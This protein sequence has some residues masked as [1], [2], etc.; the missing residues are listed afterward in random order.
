[1]SNDKEAVERYSPEWKRGLMAM[2]KV[3]IVDAFEVCLKNKDRNY[4]ALEADRDEL[5]GTF[6]LSWA[7]DMRAIKQWQ[8]ATGKDMQW[9]DRAK[10]ILWLLERDVEQT[11]T[12]SRLREALKLCR[13]NYCGYAITASVDPLK[14]LA[15]FMKELFRIRDVA[16]AALEDK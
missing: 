13:T 4:D 2:K 1:M 6:D 16:N 8:A 10:M 11:K 9:P 3:R 12:I 5:Q 7:A 15:N 14:V